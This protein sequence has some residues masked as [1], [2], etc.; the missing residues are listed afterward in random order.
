MKNDSALFTS[1]RQEWETPQELFDELDSEYHFD[2][3]AA[4]SSDNAKVKNYF[5][6]EDDSLKQKWGVQQC[7]Y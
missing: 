3:D 4:A 1:E 7:V 5:T 6:E 2:L